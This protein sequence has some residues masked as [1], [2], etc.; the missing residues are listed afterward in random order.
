[1]PGIIAGVNL[2]QAKAG[3]DRPISLV[4]VGE[5]GARKTGIAVSGS[6]VGAPRNKESGAIGRKL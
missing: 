2:L 1:M 5:I 3:L 4:L 6:P